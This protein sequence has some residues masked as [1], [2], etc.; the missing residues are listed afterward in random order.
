MI[1]LQLLFDTQHLEHYITR[2]IKQYSSRVRI[3]DNITSALNSTEVEQII[4]D[5]LSYL[6]S[7]PEA[8]YLDQLGLTR[9]DVKGLVK[10]SILSLCSEAAPFVLD[11]VADVDTDQVT[12]F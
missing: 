8:H 4:E 10:P 11:T 1:V 3:V 2:K 6:Y 5:R 9:D 7:Q 12:I